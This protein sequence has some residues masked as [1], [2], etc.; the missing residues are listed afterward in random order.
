M[1]FSVDTSITEADTNITYTASLDNPSD[2]GNPVMIN[3]DVDSAQILISNP[4]T[5]RTFLKT[6]SADEDQFLDVSSVTGAIS[7]AI[8]V[9]FEYLLVDTSSVT[10]SIQ[11]TI[12]VITLTLTAA[13]NIAESE[14]DT[15]HMMA[16]A[17]LM[18]LSS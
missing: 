11:D 4:A 16:V 10:T 6:I 13:S 17:I 18:Q 8:G 12:Q 2:V 14:G 5:G 3:L 9:N 7:S 1:I 15:R